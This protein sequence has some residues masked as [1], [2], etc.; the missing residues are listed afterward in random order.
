MPYFQIRTL[1]ILK[2]HNWPGNIRELRNFVQQ[3]VLD[4]SNEVILPENLP[5]NIFKA[6]PINLSYIVT[7]S[8]FI[9]QQ[10]KEKLDYIQNVIASSE[11]KNEAAK[12]L[13]IKPTHLQYL[14]NDSKAAKLGE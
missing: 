7:L 1:E 5:L 12:K 8:D 6:Q 2:K 11:T 14:L 13:G 4:A 9:N 3:C 10:N